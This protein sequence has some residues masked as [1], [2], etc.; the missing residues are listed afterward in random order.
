[1]LQADPTPK[2]EPLAR[3]EQLSPSYVT[4]TLRLAFLAPVIVERILAGS[5]PVGLNIQ[6][7]ITCDLPLA[8]DEQRAHLGG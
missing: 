7:L 3:A 1:M 2:L 6:R 8:W 4:R 5:Q